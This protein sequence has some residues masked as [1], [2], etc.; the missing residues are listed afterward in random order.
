MSFFVRKIE[1]AKWLQNDIISGQVPSADAITNCT[2]TNRN[3][4]SV[5]EIDKMEDINLAILALLCRQE[6]LDSID[7]VCFTSESISGKGIN[8][9]ETD[10]KTTFELMKKKHRDLS[11]LDYD[12]LGEI[13]ELIIEEIKEKR[14]IRISVGKQKEILK[15]AIKDRLID[16]ESIS[17]NILKKIA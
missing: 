5:W 16:Q 17:E 15:K 14:D 11:K 4:L 12:K 13:A 7:V 10:G 3:M 1:K 9:E 6:H 2:K 8:I